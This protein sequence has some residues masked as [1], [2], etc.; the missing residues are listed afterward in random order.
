MSD[1][2]E[3]EAASQAIT[4]GG[5]EEEDDIAAGEEAASGNF[6]APPQLVM[7]SLAMPSRRPFTEK[8][9]QM[10]RLKIAV[11]GADGVGKTSLI[12]AIV[13]QCEDIVHLDPITTQP[14]TVTQTPQPGKKP[15]RPLHV[16]E[17]QASTKA[18][19][20]WWSDMED[21]RVLRRRKSMS[22]TVLERNVSFIDSP[23]FATKSELSPD[24]L[25]LTAHLEGLFQRNAAMTELGSSELLNVLSGAGGVQVDVVLYV[26]APA[27]KSHSL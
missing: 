13:R 26:C 14:T 16:T 7:P 19:P 15:R 24:R 21:S 25:P 5:E 4:S 27:G 9:K 10:G 17:I 1:G 11:A 18:Y 3:D 8:G 20:S 2:E 6:M 22:E 12:R 23:G